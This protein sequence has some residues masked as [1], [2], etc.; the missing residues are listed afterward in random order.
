MHS[1]TVILHYV[2]ATHYR[3]GIDL[4]GTKIEGICLDAENKI[5]ARTRLPTEAQHGYS[6]I[7]GQ[8]ELII[9][10]LEAISNV[11]CTQIGIGTPGTLDPKTG[12]IKNSNTL[13]LNNQPLDQDL[14]HLIG[15][16]VRL[17]NDANCFA[18]AEVRA[19]S[20]KELNLKTEL[21][22]GI[23]M[24]TG[25][26]GGLVVHDQLIG[27]LHGIAGEWGHNYLDESGGPCYCGKTGCVETVIAGPSLERYYREQA[28]ASL[29]LKEIVERARAKTDPVAE[30][31]LERL[32]EMFGKAA[33]ELIN[34]LDP[35]ALVIGGGVGNI[36]ELYEV[37]PKRIAKYI[38]N[39]TVNT[40][41]VKP[42]LGDSAG[43]Y[44]AAYLF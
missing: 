6:H 22:F 42:T 12:L 32:L 26:G 2:M 17:A 10:T 1:S 31:T 11:P 28:G 14:A 38:F 25:V 37:G 9:K 20:I 15:R 3:Y 30:Q 29:P 13:C 43:V 35:D 36:D 8:I 23:I 21:V 27:G 24:G 41:L 4:G 16:E 34:I 39:D 5:V 44:G 33:A 40:K 7:L 19:G 18:L